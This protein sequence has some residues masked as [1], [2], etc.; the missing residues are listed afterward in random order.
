MV[1]PSV[2][3][4]GGHFGFAED[5]RP[6]REAEIG[7]DDEA[8]AL[9]ELAEQVAQQRAA[10]IAE[11]QIAKLIQDNDVAAEQP[12]G[13]LARLALGHLQFERV[14]EVDGGEEADLLAVL[15]DGL[16]AQGRRA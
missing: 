16:H 4:G 12:F 7:G 2:E 8:G 14:D 10:G 11:R 9:V 1:R 13:D 5:A 15:L 3:P 6:F